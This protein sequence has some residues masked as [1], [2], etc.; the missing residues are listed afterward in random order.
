MENKVVKFILSIVIASTISGCGYHLRGSKGVNSGASLQK[1]S[2]TTFNPYDDVSREVK[3]ALLL[4]GTKIVGAND[5][6]PQIK[7]IASGLS[8]G[9]AGKDQA[10]QTVQYLYKF[11][12]NYQVIFPNQLPQNYSAIVTEY[13]LTPTAS[14]PTAGEALRNQL[15]NELMEEAVS[16]MISQINRIQ[17][18]T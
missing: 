16:K 14:N 6:I 1:V 4:N 10:Y 11:S 7:I 13:S 12:I 3:Q 5:T 8:K 17:F 2:L 9:A 18:T 15:Q